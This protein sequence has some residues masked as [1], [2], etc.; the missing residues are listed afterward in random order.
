MN[1]LI[2]SDIH[3]NDVNVLYFK[4]ILFPTLSAILKNYN[5]NVAIMLYNTLSLFKPIDNLLKLLNVVYNILNKPGVFIADVTNPTS[6]LTPTRVWM[7]HRKY[8]N[9]DY[10]VYT[11]NEIDLVY[12]NVK[13]Y[14]LIFEIDKNNNVK[15]YLDVEE[16]RQYPADALKLAAKYVGFNDVELYGDF[17]INNRE[18]LKAYVLNLVATKV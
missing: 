1:N 7:F 12:F 9:K 17:N 3:L 13:G 8:N 18:P 10:V 11:H 14:V 2:I 16:G 4:R 15:A 5:I 6:Q